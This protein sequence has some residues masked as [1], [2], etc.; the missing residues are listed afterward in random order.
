MLRISAAENIIVQGILFDE[1]EYPIEYAS[2]FVASS[3]LP[4]GFFLNAAETNENGAFKLPFPVMPDEKIT[5]SWQGVVK[6]VL[7]KDIAAGNGNLYLTISQGL[8]PVIIVGTKPVVKE[9]SKIKIDWLLVA[10]IC[11]GLAALGGKLAMASNNEK[12]LATE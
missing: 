1:M 9:T 3:M 10:G 2:V 12:Q 4:N 8:D 7:A 5:I 6:T 11:V